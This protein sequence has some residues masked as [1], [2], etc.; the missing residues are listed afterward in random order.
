LFVLK[1]AGFVLV[2]AVLEMFV[3]KKLVVLVKFAVVLQ[4]FVSLLCG[5]KLVL[6]LASGAAI[7]LYND[8]HMV[9][10]FAWL[11]LCL[12]LM[13]WCGG[14]PLGCKA[15]V[16]GFVLVVAVLELFVAKKLVVLVKFAVGLQNFVSLLCG[17][18]LVLNL[19][20]GAAIL[21][22]NDDHMV[23]LFAWLPLCL[24]LMYWCGGLPLGRK[25]W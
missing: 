10:L 13:Y 19:T 12:A 1:V 23:F 2:V 20:F 5:A 8:D 18:K 9:F 24:A 14:L 17:A 3:A 4:N 25:T 21:L 15:W 22:D 6:N 11:P 16:D 7:L